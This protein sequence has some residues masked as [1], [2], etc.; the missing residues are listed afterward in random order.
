GSD[1]LDIGCNLGYATEAARREGFNA[2]GIEIDNDAVTTASISF[3]QNDYVCTTAEAFAKTGRRFDLL[4]CSEV[5]EHVPDMHGFA[6][7]MA[8]L[9][10]PGGHVFIT[11]PDAGHFL[12]PKHFISWNEV[13]PPE[14]VCWYSKST[15]QRLLEQHGFRIK[16]FWFTLKPGLKALAVKAS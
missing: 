15:L 1:F 7:A 8:K 3:P 9:A 5:I 2:T 4:Y 14:H 6:A 11:T 12:R 16:K 13:K 10:K